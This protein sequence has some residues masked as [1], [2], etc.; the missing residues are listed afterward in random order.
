MREWRAE[1]RGELNARRR[2]GPFPTVCADC[3]ETF[4]ARTR[5]QVR[6]P[7]CQAA[8]RRARKR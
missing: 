3:A 8:M 4:A 5:M 2:A 7:A 6:C 1:H